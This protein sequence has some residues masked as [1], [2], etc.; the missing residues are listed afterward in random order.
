MEAGSALDSGFRF[1]RLI[2]VKLTK[3]DGPRGWL[4]EETQEMIS[5]LSN[6]NEL[7]TL[8]LYQAPIKDEH[9]EIML[10]NLHS[11]RDL[12]I[13]ERLVKRIDCH[14]MLAI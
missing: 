11:L 4:P 12:E 5:L 10:S 3:W 2:A 13:S 14:Q 6:I 1:C 9:L 7:E 8:H